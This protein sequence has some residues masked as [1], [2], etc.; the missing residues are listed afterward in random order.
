MNIYLSSRLVWEHPLPL[1]IHEDQ[2]GLIQGLLL[3]IGLEQ[4]VE[5]C[6]PF[7][8]KRHPGPILQGAGYQSCT[9][10][11]PRLSAD[12][13]AKLGHAIFWPFLHDSGTGSSL[14]AAVSPLGK[15]RAFGALSHWMQVMAP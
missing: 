6:G 9:T 12:G 15:G 13:L 14:S 4:L 5:Q 3:A 8:L 7:H 2:G 1:C 11:P 10:L